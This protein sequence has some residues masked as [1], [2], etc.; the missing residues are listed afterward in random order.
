LMSAGTPAGLVPEA[1]LPS[2]KIKPKAA[3]KTTSRNIEIFII[4][5]IRAPDA[6][7]ARQARISNR[8]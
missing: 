6:F 2:A 5:P 3:V 4:L 8:G 1:Q 7:Q